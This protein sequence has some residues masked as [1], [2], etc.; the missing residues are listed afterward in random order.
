LPAPGGRVDLGA[1][2]RALAERDVLALLV[3]GGAEI[4]ASLL[5]AGLVDRVEFLVAPKIIGGGAAP[6]PPGGAGGGGGAG[7]LRLERARMRR[8]GEDWLI[9]AY[10]HRDH[11]TAGDGRADRAE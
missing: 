5:D 7:A 2:L 8:L 1:L 11:R 9:S 4:A 10:V 3:E 6:G